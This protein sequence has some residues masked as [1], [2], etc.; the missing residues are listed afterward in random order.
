LILEEAG[1]MAESLEGEAF[2]APELPS[3]S[4]VASSDPAVFKVW[5]AWLDEQA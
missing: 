4:A 5:R 3:R 1:G 2:F